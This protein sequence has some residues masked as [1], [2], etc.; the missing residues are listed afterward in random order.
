MSEI[1]LDTS[2]FSGSKY[3]YELYVDKD[4]LATVA[5]VEPGGKYAPKPGYGFYHSHSVSDTVVRLVYME[6]AQLK[7]IKSDSL[8][9]LKDKPQ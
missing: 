1:L 8:K 3:F 4:K 5:D 2:E 6:S 9:L 7:K